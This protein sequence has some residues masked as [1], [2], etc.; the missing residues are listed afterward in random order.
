M[1]NEDITRHQQF[2][3]LKKEIRGSKE[4][5]IVGIDIGKET[6][7]SFMGT[8]TGKS[9][10]RKLIFK[11]NI[12]GFTMLLAH[13]ESIK[14]QNDLSEIVF[15]LEPTGN[16][17]KPLGNHLIRC[18]YN[19]VM[20]SGVAVK[21]NRE[22]L[23]GR[24]DKHDTKCAANVADL[25]SQGKCQY[26][27]A[28]SSKIS[29][30]RDLLSLRKILKKEE[31]RL[32]LRVRNNLLAKF[33]PEF[34]R[35]FGQNKKSG[36]GVVR[37]CIDTGRIA[38]MEFNDFFNTVTVRRNSLKQK[39]RL[40]KIHALAIDSIGC[41]TNSSTEF[42]AK[43]LVAKIKL[44]SEHIKETEDII[45][46]RCQEFAEYRCLMSI[47]GFGPYISSM[48]MAKIGNPF[49]FNNRR[50]VVKMAGFDLNANRSGKS[51]AGAIPKISKKGSGD[52]RYALYQAALVASARNIH[53]I[54]YFT[55]KL[56]GRAKER[57][58]KTKMRVKLAAKMLVIAWT[59]MKHRIEFNPDFLK[60][61]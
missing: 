39:Q 38:G 22:L 58:I 44:V 23:D 21:R 50:Q 60:T 36:L 30:I 6:H 45:H 55:R 15:G 8:A 14:V 24:W 28:P 32:T 34:D 3:Q 40:I 5:L 13:V 27:E 17:H 11:N 31:H 7:H 59:L 16:Y 51:S 41:S 33:F 29:E 48:V 9:L 18:G 12:D 46:D 26:Y 49:R 61:E 42:E 4:Y 10:Y 1:N 52:L 2:E 47:P 43:L 35:Y 53:F 56:K 37:W 57:G 20:I 25:I 19:V 54:K